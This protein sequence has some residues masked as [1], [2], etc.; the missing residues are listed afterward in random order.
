MA[1]RYQIPNQVTGISDHADSWDEAQEIRQQNINAYV[2]HT[3]GDLFPITI[4]IENTDGTITQRRCDILGNP[5]P[6]PEEQ[7][8]ALRPNRPTE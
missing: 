5:L 7:L 2:E 3:A 8:L 6:T 4:L 1:V